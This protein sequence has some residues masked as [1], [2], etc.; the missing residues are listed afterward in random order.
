MSELILAPENFDIANAW[1]TYGSI[2]E[3]AEQLM[4][5]RHEVA[6][7]LNKAEVKRY[8]DAVYLDAGYRNRNKLASLMDRM[9][10]AKIEEAEESGIY[11]KKDLVEILTLAHK[12]RMDEIKASKEIPETTTNVNIANFGGGAYGDLMERLIK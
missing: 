11:S 1:L 3:V 2:D 9:I 6:V 5:P 4:I 10:D 12:M 7:A 8:L